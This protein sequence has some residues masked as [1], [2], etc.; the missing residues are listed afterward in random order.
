MGKTIH[1]IYVSFLL[2]IGLLSVLV[3]SVKGGSYYT[4]P[5]QERPFHPLYSSLKPTGLY[6]STMVKK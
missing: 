6:G 2:V 4:T 1:S 3:I 5:L